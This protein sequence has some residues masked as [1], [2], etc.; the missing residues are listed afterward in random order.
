[1]NKN[2]QAILVVAIIA[3]MIVTV[4]QFWLSTPD[5]IPNELQ[6]FARC[7]T[8]RDVVMYGADWCPHCQEEKAAFGAAFEL[9]NYVECPEEPQRCLAAGI[10]NYPTWIFPDGRKFVG[11]QGPERLAELSGCPLPPDLFSTP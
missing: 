3:V 4:R 7:L 8:D 11:R 5:R 6:E 2:A 9:I 10:Q 1:M